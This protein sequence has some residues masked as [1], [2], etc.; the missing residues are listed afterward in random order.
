MKRQEPLR[1]AAEQAELDRKIQ[2]VTAAASGIFRANRL[3]DELA[4]N[5]YTGK[6]KPRLLG[7]DLSCALALAEKETELR[8]KLKFYPK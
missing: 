4:L 3:R 8:S 6:E 7:D 1:S 2:E 5:E